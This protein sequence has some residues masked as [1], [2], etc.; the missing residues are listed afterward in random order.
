MVYCASMYS[1]DTFLMFLARRQY[2][3]FVSCSRVF[4]LT[5]PAPR[6]SLCRCCLPLSSFYSFDVGPVHVVVLN[7]Y[8]AS[9]ENSE[10][11]GWLQKVQRNTETPV[12]HT[13]MWA[14]HA[15]ALTRYRNMLV[16]PENW[17]VRVVCSFCHHLPGALVCLHV[18]RTEYGSTPK[19]V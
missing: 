5:R 17:V 7:P 9:G 15:S 6:H 12:P 18:R 14:R 13:R 1:K 3:L 16:L 2:R 10:Q 19:K 11:L 4:A 8:T